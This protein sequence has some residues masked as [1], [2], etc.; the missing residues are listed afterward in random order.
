LLVK[1]ATVQ[2]GNQGG[3]LRGR[4]NDR[5]ARQ[6]AMAAVAARE[7]AAERAKEIEETRVASW[8]RWHTAPERIMALAQG[9]HPVSTAA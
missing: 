2:T 3:P 5:V 1:I 9:K 7:Q 4:Q 6:E 8:A